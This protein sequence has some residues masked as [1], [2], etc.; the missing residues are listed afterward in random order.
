MESMYLKQFLDWSYLNINNMEHETSS[1]DLLLK[2]GILNALAQ[3]FKIGHREKLLPYVTTAV[4][5]CNLINKSTN[6]TLI[7]K[8][9]TKLYQRIGMNFLPPKLSTWRYDR[10]QRS[11]LHNLLSELPTIATT[12]TTSTSNMPLDV[13]QKQQQN[14][15]NDF[16]TTNE[17][18]EIEKA[19]EENID[20]ENDDTA[21]PVEVEEII[22][23]LLAS[24]CD[25]DS[26]VRWSAAKGIGRISM[27]LSKA[28]VDDVVM[29]I[30]ELFSE[31]NADSNWH[32]GCLALAEL[33]RRG[34]LLPERLVDVMPIV[35]KAL[36]Y[37][38]MRGQFSVGA[39]VRDAACYVCWAFSRAYASSV[40]KPYISMLSICMLL[41]ALFDREI[42][43]RRAASAAFQESVGR[44][45]NETFPCGIEIITIANYFSLGNRKNA[46]LSIA[47]KIATF[48]TLIYASL[49][50]NLKT[51]KLYH[52][53]VEIR[54]LSAK[55]IAALVYVDANGV[56]ASMNEFIT[57]CT[58]AQVNIRHG[59][60]LG[61]AECILT[62]AYTDVQLYLRCYKRGYR[63]NR[64]QFRETTA[65]QR[66]WKRI[67]TMC[68]L[69]I[70]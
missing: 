8:L 61:V 60:L 48:N 12:T 20:D 65:V 13:Q 35:Q 9:I 54:V 45:G 49:L 50:E 26:V 57:N 24:I 37:D 59:A 55:A 23:E 7:R 36:Q 16:T 64:S 3:I 32:G 51:V 19:N 31:T 15:N 62:L 25:K 10:G 52:W 70:A 5:I 56:V 29:A 17:N 39:H 69:R 1:K 33:S 53:D 21:I 38:I 63:S 43:C 27:R 44:Q 47:P 58:S 46:Y 4:N 68:H 6:Q 30:I 18:N 2:I 28:L 67:N 42:N 11:L 22:N 40:L 34:L 14:I 41:T 66:S